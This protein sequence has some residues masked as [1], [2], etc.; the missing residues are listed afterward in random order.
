MQPLTLSKDC[1]Q[2]LGVLPNLCTVL[3]PAFMSS[4]LVLDGGAATPRWSRAGICP[5]RISCLMII[6]LE[7]EQ[8]LLRYSLSVEKI[9]PIALFPSS[10][11]TI[12]QALRQP[13]MGCPRRAT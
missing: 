6:Q 13:S 9:C 12:R 11:S 3:D 1:S 8:S 4:H 5:W 7:L 2:F 10:S